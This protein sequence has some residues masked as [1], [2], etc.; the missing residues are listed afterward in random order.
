MCFL[1]NGRKFEINSIADTGSSKGIINAKIVKENNLKVEK[2]RRIKLLNANGKK[3][4]VDGIVKLKCFPKFINKKYNQEELRSI[5]TEFIVSPDLKSRL[6]L[7]CDNLKE[8]GS[9]SKDFANVE[10]DEEYVSRSTTD[11][12]DNM[13]GLNYQQRGD[14]YALLRE[15]HDIFKDEIDDKK[16]IGEECGIVFKKNVKIVPSKC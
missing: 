10:V 12:G 4:A 3:M 11:I 14:S 2:G 1:G 13:V 5:D 15:Y 7:S 9:I 16:H 8:M 6:L